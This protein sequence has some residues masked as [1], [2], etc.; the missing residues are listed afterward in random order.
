MKERSRTQK[1]H[2]REKERE[3]GVCGLVGEGEAL[4]GNRGDTGE[5]YTWETA[6]GKLCHCKQSAPICIMNVHIGDHSW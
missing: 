5:E 3:G 4:D 1:C 2:S 6:L